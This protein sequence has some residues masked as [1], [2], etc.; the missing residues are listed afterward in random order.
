V[1]YSRTDLGPLSPAG[2]IRKMI[3]DSDNSEIR[4]VGAAATSAGAA[5]IATAASAC[6]I[7]IVAPLVV[8][9]L[10]ASGAAWAVGLKPYSLYLLVG[11]LGLLTFGFWS[12]YRPKRACADGTCP[13]GR[14]NAAR[15]ARVILWFAAALWLGAAVLNILPYLAPRVG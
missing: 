13:P 15:A 9:V 11:S 4:G 3:M 14:S 6:C 5:A 10:G 2:W 7:P 8:T 1:L 12:V